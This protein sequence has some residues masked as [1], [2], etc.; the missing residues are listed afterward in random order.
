[1][2]QF[3]ASHLPFTFLILEA[4]SFNVNQCGR[5]SVNIS[6]KGVRMNLHDEIIL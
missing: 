1:L 4:V 2:P 5:D 6:F 3:V